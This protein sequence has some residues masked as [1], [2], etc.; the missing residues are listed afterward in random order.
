MFS[1]P[2]Q[3]FVVLLQNI[4]KNPQH[5]ALPWLGGRLLQWNAELV[6]VGLHF[7]TM[8]AWKGR[9]CYSCWLACYFLFALFVAWIFMTALQFVDYC[10]FL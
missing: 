1:I 9:V 3:T 5:F 8:V 10:A 7:N 6:G 4:Q 2:P